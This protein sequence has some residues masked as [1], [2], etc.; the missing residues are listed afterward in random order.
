M[1]RFA[2]KI[3]FYDGL[4]SSKM[5]CREN[6]LSEE[7]GELILDFSD[8]VAGEEEN[9][10]YC[11]QRV[12]NRFA[13][14]YPPMT[15]IQD[16]LGSLYVN[17]TLPKLFGLMAEDFDP[18]SLISSGILRVQR[19]PLSLSGN[20]VVL[21]FVD[22]GIRYAEEV[23]R[24]QAG[25]TRVLAIWD[26]SVQSGMPPEGYAYGSL[27]TRE[28]INNALRAENPYT[29]VPSYDEIG[30]GT[31][32]ASVAAGS[33]TGG[34][35][36]FRGAAPETDIVVV[37]LREAKQNLRDFYRIPDTAHAYA[38]TDI[39]L[40]VK[41]AESFAVTFRRPVVI[42]IGVGTNWGNHTTG[43][44]LAQYLNQ[45]A[46]AR[47]RG[48]VICGGNEGNA[49]HHYSAPVPAGRTETGDAYRDVEIRVAEGERGFLL[50]TWGSVPDVLYASLRTPGGETI[51]PFRLGMGQSLTYGF[52]YERTQVIIDSILVEPGSG[53]E[54]IIFRFLNPTAGVWTIRIYGAESG[55]NGEFHMWLPITGF[56]SGETYFLNPSPYVTLTDPGMAENAITVSAYQ[57]LN[58]SFYVNSGRGFLRNGM[59]KP[60]LAAPGVDVSASMGKMT[61][62]SLA[63]AIT[64]GGVAQFFQWAVVQ[65]NA[66]L[67]ESYEIKSYFIRGAERDAELVYPNREWGYGRLQVAG[68]FDAL[69]GV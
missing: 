12:N 29:L 49:A 15:E 69:A 33:V 2:W 51:P 27:Y 26:Q 68:A 56:L 19:P 38:E 34:G 45:I 44:S 18:V 5:S 54:L 50:E 55:G 37:K 10:R 48:V 66:P 41:F 22:T 14:A 3:L 62:S 35:R 1:R 23:F 13:V 17:R 25:N 24:N 40:G 52:V 4:F 42:C 32:M 63:A 46:G 61:G 53:D 36:D 21:A 20:G 11:V 28:D 64:A 59:I 16:V 30:H 60:D 58:N 57:D 65:R 43:S 47:S 9:R 39:M 6:I 31:A 8:P 7:Y 67:A